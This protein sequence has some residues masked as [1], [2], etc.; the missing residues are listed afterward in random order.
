MTGVQTCA[1]PICVEVLRGGGSALY[2]SSAIGGTINV[3]TKE[4]LRSM[5]EASHT[6]TSLG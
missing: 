4:P 6:I 1:L 3:I 2:G 5:A